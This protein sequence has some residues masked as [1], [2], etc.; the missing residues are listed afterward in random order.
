MTTN[1]FDD[2]SDEDLQTLIDETA[3]LLDAQFASFNE[4]PP[5]DDPAETAQYLYRHITRVGRL[6]ARLTAMKRERAIRVVR[7][8][9]KNLD[10]LQP[11]NQVSPAVADLLQS[12]SFFHL[13]V[14]GVILR[15]EIS[16]TQADLAKVDWLVKAARE[17]AL[18]LDSQQIYQNEIIELNDKLDEMIAALQWVDLL[19]QALGWT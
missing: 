1:E 4:M 8:L 13:D 12:A 9:Q 17:T 5:S 18:S 15:D 11:L 16:R 19:R 3:R 2:L 7:R 10:D 6:E 14:I